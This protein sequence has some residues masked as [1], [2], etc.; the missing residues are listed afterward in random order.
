MRR[1][2]LAVLLLAGCAAD[3]DVRR[4]SFPMKVVTR[5]LDLQTDVGEG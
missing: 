4:S 2:I 5:R 3:V 1:L